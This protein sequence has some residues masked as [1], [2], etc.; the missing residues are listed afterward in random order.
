M[1]DGIYSLGRFFI[2]GFATPSVGFISVLS[3]GRN[4]EI[5]ER[6]E[7]KRVESRTGM[8]EKFRTEK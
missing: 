1:K 7:R 6:H 2:R 5:R 8:T 4:H 3:R